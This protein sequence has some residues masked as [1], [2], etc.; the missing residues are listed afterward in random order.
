VGGKGLTRYHRADC[1]LAVGRDWPAADLA[2]HALAGR[3]PCGV[4]RP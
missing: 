2:D 4:C 1:A 3:M